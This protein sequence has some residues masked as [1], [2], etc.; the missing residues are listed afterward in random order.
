MCCTDGLCEKK[1]K[2]IRVYANFS[3]RLNAALKDFDI[4]L[5]C[6]DNIIA[7]LKGGKIF[8]KIDLSDTY[9]QIPVEDL[10]SKQLYINMHRGIYKFKRLLFEVKF[11]PGIFQQMMDTMLSGF[12]FAVVYL[13]DILM[14]SKSIIEHKNHVHKVLTKIQDYDFKLKETKCDFFHEKKSNTWVTLLTRMVED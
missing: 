5:P 14:K 3:T 12:D 9:V 1:S 10:S 4:P 7:K 13:A 11:A 8:S 2:E 6:S